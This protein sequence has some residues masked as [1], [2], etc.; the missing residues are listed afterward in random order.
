[1]MKDS[2]N[3]ATEVCT[4]ELPNHRRLQ[5]S[6]PTNKSTHLSHISPHPRPDDAE[7]KEVELATMIIPLT[8]LKARTARCI[9]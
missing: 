1:M 8:I 4:D 7:I 5:Q 3:E 2:R 9:V 6:S